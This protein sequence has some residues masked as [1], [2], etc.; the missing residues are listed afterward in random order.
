MCLFLSRLKQQPSMNNTTSRFPIPSSLQD[1]EHPPY[2]LLPYPNDFDDD[3]EA[4]RAQSFDRLVEFLDDGAKALTRYGIQLFLAEDGSDDEEPWLDT[5]RMQALYTLVRKS[6]SLANRTRTNFISALCRTVH[7]LCHILVRGNTHQS[8][9]TR[10]LPPS[11]RDA[12]SCHVYMLFSV[13]SA[14][15]SEIKVGKGLVIAT[16]TSK[17]K[18]Q[19]KDRGTA[20]N[21]EDLATQ[22]A[23]RATCAKA[24]QTA[25]QSM[26][27]HKFQLWNHG[28]VQED[29]LSLPCQIS[30][31]ILEN[32]TNSTN[33]KASCGD[34]A[35]A[36]LASTVQIPSMISTI[37][38]ALMDLLHTHEHLAPLVAELCTLEDSANQQHNH[39]RLTMELFREIGRMDVVEGKASGSKNVAPFLSELASRKPQ[40]VLAHIGLVLSH[41]NS[42][43]YVFRSSIVTTIGY[44]L[45]R[46][47]SEGEISATNTK[48]NDEFATD[49]NMEHYNHNGG[50]QKTR[51]SLFDLLTERIHDVSSYTRAA[52][53]KAWVHLIEN[54]SI[55]AD[56]FLSVTKLAIDRLQD[57]TVIVRK[58]A[59]QVRV[60]TLL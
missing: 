7:Q 24:M 17:K 15:E 47:D 28:V 1:L 45:T 37:V 50:V 3:N 23:S 58:N 57:K 16:T 55:P 31:L 12:F 25:A 54:D 29:L 44:I 11:F 9:T 48:E 49:D 30:Y 40:L 19:D 14:V 52:V 35:L 34:D 53:L 6:A 13:M 33:R 38:A 18:G 39:S 60:S 46:S 5:Y 10:T 2:N 43:S 26:I 36:I 41:L 51:D 21:K 56:R 4:A 8:T 22:T 59:L 32:S 20:S 27:Q 42:E